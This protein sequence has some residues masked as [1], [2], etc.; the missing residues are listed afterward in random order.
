MRLYAETRGF[1]LGRPVAVK[2]TPDGK[3]VLFLRAPPT[4]PRLHLFELSVDTGQTR[5]LL[6][7]EAV[8]KGA[9][10]QLS[11]EEKARRERMRVTVGGFSSFELSDDGNL[12][13]LPLSGKLYLHDRKTS[14]TKELPTGAGVIDPRMS[15]N[16][17]SVG[18]VQD[19]D[20]HVMDLAALKARAVTTGGTELVT[21][22]LAEFVA[23]EEMGRMRGFW[24]S[25][26]TTQLAYEEADSRDVE[27]FNIS[28][29]M[30]PEKKPVSFRYPRAGKKNAEVKLGVIP[31]K[32][33]KTTWIDWDQARYPYLAQVVW[34]KDAP[35]T[36][37]V[38][39]R[40]QREQLLLAA[41]PAK[42][43][44]TTLLTEKDDA[45][46]NLDPS[47]PM[48]LPGG[49][50]FLWT[51]ERNGA[52]E[53]EH[54]D[55]KGQLVRTLVPVGAG[56]MSVVDVD[57]KTGKVHVLASANPVETQLYSVPL[58]GGA[59]TALTNT[60][61]RRAVTF[62]RNH[63][64]YVETRVPQDGWR[65]AEVRSAGGKLMAELPQVNVAPPFAPNAT[66]Q[67]VGEGTGLHTVL[68][69]PRNF[70]PARLYPVVVSVYGG[71]HHNMVN[72]AWEPYLREQWIADH[73]YMVVC[74]DGRGTQWRGRAW[75][76][77]ISGDFS[78][79]PLQDQVTGVKLLAAQHPQMDLG[80]VGILGWSFG[81]YMA[82]LA[83]TTVN[84]GYK[85]F[86]SVTVSPALTKPVCKTRR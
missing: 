34:E 59:L 11:V 71:P 81:G 21:H 16:G 55:A 3:H 51:T 42:G 39:S 67:K 69:K 57:V 8:L 23:Q 45:W 14:A 46:V 17:K 1:N 12:I 43:T 63:Q 85:R 72:A 74:V 61:A 35:L 2:P 62:S 50:G 56:L 36:L 47:M 79:L 20:V 22:G 19:N 49:L 48:W 38:Q 54:H 7:P 40:D 60:P 32:G 83:A 33:G 86:C 28:D 26:D 18:Y 75:E 30:H 31:I 27:E 5:E 77:A 44:T 68:F 15:P 64:L 58:Q 37:L 84:S 9:E 82:A 6:T 41:D 29:P 70:D 52:W 10:E 24:W 76:R 53:L 78:T 25:P 13:L 73:G 80:R 4:T 66:W 65:T